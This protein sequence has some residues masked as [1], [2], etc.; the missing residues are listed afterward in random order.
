MTRGHPASRQRG[1]PGTHEQAA[2]AADFGG[3]R[4]PR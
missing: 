2:F 4:Q 3:R 1:T